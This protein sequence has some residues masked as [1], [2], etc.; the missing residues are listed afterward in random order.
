MYFFLKRFFDLLISFIMLVLLLP[1]F[2]LIMFLMMIFHN[3]Y[4]FY[5]QQRLGKNNIYF[6]LIKFASMLKNSPNMQGGTITTRKDPRVTRMGRILRITKLNELPQ[7]INVLIGDMSFVGPRPMLQIGFEMYTKEVQEFLYK[8]KPGITGIASVVFRD[9]EKWV[10]ESKMEPMEFYKKY[11]FPYKGELEQWY[12]HN[13]S[14][15]TDFKIILLT[16]IKIVFSKS[17][18]EYRFFKNLPRSEYFG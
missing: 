9:E 14:L 2:I 4:I 15:F 12:Y 1:F 17:R 5:I 7:I 8:S 13:R 3:A 11:V 6:G 18:L 16:A 10:T